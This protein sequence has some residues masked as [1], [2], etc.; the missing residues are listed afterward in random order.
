MPYEDVKASTR[1]GQASSLYRTLCPALTSFPDE[2]EAVSGSHEAARPPRS[3]RNSN[4]HPSRCALVRARPLSGKFL[5]SGSDTELAV[6][7][8][9]TLL[10]KDS[11]VLGL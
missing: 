1:T 8:N 2:D 9:R 7:I 4:R 10:R 6:A 3:P 5:R 11:T